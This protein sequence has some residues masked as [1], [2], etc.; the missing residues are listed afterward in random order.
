MA[1]DPQDVCNHTK[2]RLIAAGIAHQQCTQADGTEVSIPGTGKRILIGNDAYLAKVVAPAVSPA[3]AAAGIEGL[4]PWH[5]NELRAYTITAP[6]GPFY[7]AADVERL[8]GAHAALLDECRRDRDALRANLAEARLVHA[9]EPAKLTD[10][11]IDELWKHSCEV[12]GDTTQQ[13]VR[14]FARAV[15]A[16]AGT[17]SKLAL[18]RIDENG[19]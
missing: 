18:S 1:M 9:G 15:L 14:H 2:I 12:S 3:P 16:H 11:R 4:L 10:E 5:L 7:V 17:E 6:K 13:F 19:K 8:L